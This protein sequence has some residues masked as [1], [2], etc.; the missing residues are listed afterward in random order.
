[1]YIGS[2][3]SIL[4]GRNVVHSGTP[5]RLRIGEYFTCY[6]LGVVHGGLYLDQAKGIISNNEWAHISPKAV[7]SAEN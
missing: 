1:M 2:I 3:G 6:L 4:H 7:G 5:L